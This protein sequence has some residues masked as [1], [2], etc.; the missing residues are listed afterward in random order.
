MPDIAATRPAS[1]P[2]M[3]SLR[4]IA[5]I[6]LPMTG[7]MLCHLGI[8]M[9]DLWVTG[10]I[11]SS[12]QAALGVVAQIFIVLML[13]TS[14]AGS[15]CLAAVSQALGAGNPLRARR[16]AGLIVS[17]AF[18]AGS[19]VG[20]VAYLLLPGFMELFN[21][22]ED[23]APALRV[24][25]QAYCL[26]L[27]FFYC[28]I[29]LNSV[30]RAHKLVWLPFGAFVLVL[31]ANFAG[32]AG[33]GLGWWGLPN[34][35]YAGVAW[36]TFGS[37]LLGLACNLAAA[38]RHRI[39]G[40]S[41][42]APW[43]W[44]RR[45]MPYIFKVG[46]P[47]ALGQMAA[48]GGGL[49]LLAMLTHLPD[50]AEQMAGQMSGQVDGRTGGSLNG[51]AAM[52]LGMRLLSVALFPL[53]AISLT[54]AI[55]SGHL[56]GARQEE[57]LYRFGLRAARLNFLLFLLP[58]AL[59]FMLR[60]PLAAFFSYEQ[61]V[62]EKASLYL[63]FNSLT[64][65]CLAVTT[66]LGGINSGAGA[67]RF[68]CLVGVATMWGVQLPLA[69]LLAYG[70]GWGERGIFMAMPAADLAAM[71]CMLQVYRSKKWLACGLKK[72]QPARSGIKLETAT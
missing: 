57:T 64:L 44:N 35:G 14:I 50:A 4:A 65:P 18:T 30:F 71:L 62:L 59:I 32:S 40:R 49:V 38:R 60:E 42:F 12:V 46:L 48:Q 8:S 31:A 29:L 45:A 58:A 24:F 21:V 69:W 10:R 70:L 11:D 33:F 53:G 7:L 9:T 67:T 37:T 13:I 2:A 55:F 43:K 34:F 3:P 25:L 72:R 52:T 20:G 28:L 36:S 16:Y 41:S 19:L 6:A 27:P 47:S 68:N 61:A 15:G 39:L 63:A 22:P 54:L 23:V 51:V 5:A 66:A 26:Q 17:L 56:L 1:G